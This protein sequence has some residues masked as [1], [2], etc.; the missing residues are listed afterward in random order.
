MIIGE[1]L[2]GQLCATE[3]QREGL[4]VQLIS[5]GRGFGGRMGEAYMELTGYQDALGD[6]RH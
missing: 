2:S 5:K 6:R 1:G 4:S 3:L